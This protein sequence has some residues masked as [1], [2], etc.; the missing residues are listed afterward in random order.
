M[1]RA[2]PGTDGLTFDEEGAKPDTGRPQRA[3][4]TLIGHQEFAVGALQ[5]EPGIAA[6]QEPGRRRWSGRRA[7]QRLILA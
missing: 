4:L 1:L 6:R 3:A 7:E 5:Q 2:P